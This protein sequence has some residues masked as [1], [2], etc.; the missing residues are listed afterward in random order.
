MDDSIDLSFRRDLVG[1]DCYIAPNATVRGNVTIG[2][3]CTVLFGSVMRGDADAISIGDFSNIQD[4]VCL[5]ADPGYPLLIGQRVTV[6]HGAI[7]HGATV[8][9]DCLIGMRATILNGAVIGTGSIVA[10]G[11]LVREGQII[12]PRSLVMGLPGKIVRECGE[13]EIEMIE[14]GWRHYVQIGQMY[15]RCDR[16]T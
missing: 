2:R 10:A 6:G 5:H 4:L 7:V 14:R 8:E 11:A 9:S 1:P 12:P 16:K 13:I 15:L 3:S